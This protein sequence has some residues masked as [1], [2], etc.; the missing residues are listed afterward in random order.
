[1]IWLTDTEYNEQVKETDNIR[2]IDLKK[3]V[4]EYYLNQ[5]DLK[6]LRKN[7]LILS[8]KGQEKYKRIKN[9][10]E[11]IRTILAENGVKL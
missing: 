8:S 7:K 3:M 11:K 2:Y 1:M 4:N 9:R 10:Q 6:N 5:I